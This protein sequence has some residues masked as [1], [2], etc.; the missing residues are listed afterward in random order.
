M[1]VYFDFELNPNADLPEDPKSVVYQT[2]RQFVQSRYKVLDDEL[3]SNCTEDNRPFC[4]LL[5][6]PEGL[7]IRYVDIDKPLLA[8]VQ[9]CISEY[10]FGYMSDVIWKKIQ[11]EKRKN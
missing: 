9:E 10:D 8:R 1:D 2:L 11:A 3:Y 4:V 7:I 6:E 5:L